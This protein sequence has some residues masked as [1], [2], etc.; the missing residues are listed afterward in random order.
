MLSPF[1]FFRLQTVFSLASN[2]TTCTGLRPV[3]FPDLCRKRRGKLLSAAVREPAAR[4][5]GLQKETGYGSFDSASISG[6]PCSLFSFPVL[7]MKYSLMC[8]VPDHIVKYVVYI[9]YS[10][11]MD[12]ALLDSLIK[13]QHP[14]IQIFHHLRAFPQVTAAPGWPRSPSRSCGSGSQPWCRPRCPTERS[15]R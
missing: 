4:I 10:G 14:F 2:F 12:C 7:K 1:L 3:F 5:K 15:A 9:F 11:F 6:L 13:L 8:S